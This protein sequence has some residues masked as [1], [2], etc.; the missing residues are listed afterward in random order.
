MN[1]APCRGHGEVQYPRDNIC[2]QKAV[3]RILLLSFSVKNQKAEGAMS[4][5]LVIVTSDIRRCFLGLNLIFC[6]SVHPESPCQ[7][8]ILR[9]HTPEALRML[10]T[11]FSH[12]LEPSSVSSLQ[13]LPPGKTH[14]TRSV[15]PPW[16]QRV[17]LLPQFLI[18]SLSV[19]LGPGRSYL[20]TASGFEHS[21]GHSTVLLPPRL[22]LRSPTSTFVS[23]SP[24]SYKDSELM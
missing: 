7:S 14:F 3:A 5:L 15:S 12:A 4:Q 6:C 24:A 19:F 11:V 16:K 9:I 18:L 10:V 23:W 17:H 20:T 1:S 22:P 21:Q 13:K 2:V 8:K